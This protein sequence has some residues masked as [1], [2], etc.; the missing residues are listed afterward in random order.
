MSHEDW[1]EHFQAE[2]K[3]IKA[4]FLEDHLY[5]A[6]FV[7][8]SQSFKPL[9]HFKLAKHSQWKDMRFAYTQNFDRAEKPDRRQ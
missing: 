1:W 5:W 8:L 4:R 9:S 6:V 3:D 7:S 2:A